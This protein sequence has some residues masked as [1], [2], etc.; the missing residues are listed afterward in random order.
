MIPT[1]LELLE[2]QIRAAA[3]SR[4]YRDVARM[5]PEYG[6]AVRAFMQS[7][8][9][10][11]ARAAEAART[12][13][14]SINWSLAMLHAARFACAAELRCVATATRYARPCG[15]RERPASIHLEA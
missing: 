11:D 8:P 5:V 4:R 10:G 2:D 12:L 6:Q 1:P 15:F 3:A 13:H 14:E 9:E 7:L